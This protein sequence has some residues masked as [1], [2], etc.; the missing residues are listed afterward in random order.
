MWKLNSPLG[1]WG[2]YWKLYH[3]TAFHF[4][5]VLGYTHAKAIKVEGS[6]IAAATVSITSITSSAPSTTLLIS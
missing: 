4:H 1:G 6:T 2:K 5:R 3:L